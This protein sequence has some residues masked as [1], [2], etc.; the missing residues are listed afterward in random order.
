MIQCSGA[1]VGDICVFTCDEG[2]ELSGSSSRTCQDDLTWSGI[3]TMCVKGK[4]LIMSAQLYINLLDLLCSRI[5][6]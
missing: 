4:L 2:Y 3:D 6:L 5:S 1:S